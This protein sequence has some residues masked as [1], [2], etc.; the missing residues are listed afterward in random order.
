MEHH[1][2]ETIDYPKNTFEFADYDR[3]GGVSEERLNEFLQWEKQNNLEKIVYRDENECYEATLIKN[4]LTT[5]KAFAQFG[6]LLGTFPPMVMFGR[7]VADSV[8]TS[9]QLWLIPFLSFVNLVCAFAGHFSGK[10]VSKM[11]AEVEKWNWANMLVILPFIG[12]LWGLI[13]GGAGGLVIFG[14][15]AI[16]GAIIAAAVGGLSLPVFT[17]FHRLLKKGD[18]I[19]RNLFLPISLGVALIVSA[20]ILGLNIK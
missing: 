10:I 15:G 8:S 5:E 4:P 16:F 6:L 20:Y 3:E 11:V 2:T 17:I 7:F 13:A 1:N 12:I 18:V 19:E 9:E 14:I